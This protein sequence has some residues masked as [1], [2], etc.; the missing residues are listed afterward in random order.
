MMRSYLADLATRGFSGPPRAAGRARRWGQHLDPLVVADCLDVH[1][2]L[3][4]QFA[5]G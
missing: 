3:L 1:A 4:G 5:N 2:A